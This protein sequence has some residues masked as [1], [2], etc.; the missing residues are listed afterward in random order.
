MV[1]VRAFTEDRESCILSKEI[2]SKNKSF[3]LPLRVL[4]NFD[5]MTAKGMS[6]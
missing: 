1:T 5:L 3:A 2:F 6:G 4:L